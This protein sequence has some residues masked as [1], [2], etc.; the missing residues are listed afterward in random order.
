MMNVLFLRHG[1]DKGAIKGV[2]ADEGLT[3]KG[4]NQI[5]AIIPDLKKFDL[6]F[7]IT[8]P[9]KRALETTKL[10]SQELAISYEINTN[11]TEFSGTNL[12]GIKQE[13][14]NQFIS[15]EKNLHGYID[16]K[17]HYDGIETYANFFERIS[18]FWNEFRNIYFQKYNNILIV[19]HGRLLTFLISKIMDFKMDGYRFAIDN[20]SYLN[21]KLTDTWR[22]QI[23][24]Q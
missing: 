8:S 17:M 9:L 19:S 7:I 13:E 5:K 22:P 12:D 18:S 4:I 21:I 23:T 3:L 1:E 15:F 16:Y 6:E 14:Y 2:F 10:I 11:L 20:G 24:F